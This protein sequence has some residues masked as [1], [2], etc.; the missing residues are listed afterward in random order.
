MAEPLGTL[1]GVLVGISRG[2]HDL[3]TPFEPQEG[4]REIRMTSAI[5][6]SISKYA[7][8]RSPEQKLRELSAEANQGKFQIL[9]V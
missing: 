6:S 1:Y 2:S 3:S 7:L 8:L 5:A 4:P 9:A